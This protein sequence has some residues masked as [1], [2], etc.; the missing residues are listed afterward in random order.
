MYDENNCMAG[1]AIDAVFP[2]NSN[3]F[4]HTLKHRLLPHSGQECNN[5]MHQR[6]TRTERHHLA[7]GCEAG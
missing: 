2:P 3:S 4:L 7:R 1:N 6:T 5:R